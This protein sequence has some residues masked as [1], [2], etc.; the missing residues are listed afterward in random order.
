ML[1]NKIKIA[2]NKSSS[3]M[4]TAKLVLMTTAVL[5]SFLF[6]SVKSAYAVCSL[7]DGVEGEMVYNV[8]Y[9]VAQFCDGT[10]WIGMTSGATS[11][12]SEVG[13]DIYFNSG[14]VGIGVNDPATTL[15]LNGAMSYREMVAP[16][17]APV[18]QGRIYFD[19][20]SNTFKV[21]ENNGAY[22]DLVGGGAAAINDL[23]DGV[24][25][26]TSVF[27]GSGSGV[28]DNG[29]NY[30]TAV[31]IDSLNSM[32]S[33][34][35]NTAMGYQSLYNHTGS[36]NTATGS[37]ALYTNTGNN[38]TATGRNAMYSNSTGHSNAAFGMD[39]LSSNTDGFYN[40][41]FGLNSLST[42]TT[43]DYNTA[44]G[45]AALRSN[46]GGNYNTAV[47][48]IALNDNTSGN[49]NTATGRGS[50]SNNT[51]G[52]NNTAFGHE[53]L[54]TNIGGNYNAAFGAHALLNTVGNN[55]TAVGFNALLSNRAKIESTAIG[56]ASMQYADDTTSSVESY[57][58]AVGAYSLHGSTTASANTGTWN[59]ALGHSALRNN[60][61]G[62]NNTAIGYQ[63]LISNT[64]G[65]ANVASGRDSLMSNTTGTQNT[66]VGYGSLY[67]NV[68]GSY[69][70]SIGLNSLFSNVGSRYNIAI[71]NNAMQYAND[72]VNTS[73]STYNIAIGHNALRGST[74]PADNDGRWNTAVGYGSL[75]Y[76]TSGDDNMGYGFFTLN[77]NT[78]GRRNVAI[79]KMALYSNVGRTENTAVGHHSM[80]Y[81]NN[82]PTY[83]IESNNTALGAYSLH[84]SGDAAVNTGR[85][86]TALGHSAMRGNT[87]GNDNVAVGWD[88]LRTNTSG[89]S[90]TAV[91]NSSLAASA[92]G[93]YNTASGFESLLQN[94]SGSNN[95]AMGYNALLS[96]VARSGSTAIGSGSMQYADDT[97]G[98]F[99][100]NTAIGYMALQGS[101]TAANNT[102]MANTAIGDQV[103]RNNT[104]GSHNTSL[105]R[106]SLLSNTVGAGNL[107]SGEFALLSNVAKSESTALGYESMRYADSG[108]AADGSD[109]S[110]NTAVGAYSLQ[111]STTAADN[112]GTGNTAIGHTAL[113]ANTSGSNNT[114][115]GY[116]AGDNITTGSSNIIIG[117]GV[118][119]MTVDGDNQ[120]NI[121]NLIHG[122]ADTTDTNLSQLAFG[123]G[124][125]AFVSGIGVDMNTLTSSMRPP[126][127]TSAQQPTCDVT[128]A[129]AFRYN[130]DTKAM[131][132]CD[133]SG[134]WAALGAGS[135][136]YANGF[137]AG[138]KNDSPVSASITPGT[139]W[140]DFPGVSMDL[141]AAGV[142]EV[143]FN[144][145][146][147]VSGG[148]Y[149]HA[150]YAR[151]STIAGDLSGER[152]FAGSNTSSVVSSTVTMK[153][154]FTVT[155]PDTIRLQGRDPY[156]GGSLFVYNPSWVWHRLDVAGSTGSNL[157]RS[158]VSGWPDNIKCNVTNPDWGILKLHSSLAPSSD[159]LYY[160]DFFGTSAQVKFNA[161]G[162]HNSY[163]GIVASDCDSKTITE[164]YD[165]YQAF[166]LVGG[167]TTASSESMA[168]GW[169]DVI[170]CDVTGWG[171]VTLSLTIAP[172]SVDGLYYYRHSAST[173]YDI[174]YN[175][176][177]TY[178]S[179]TNIAANDCNKSIT[180]LY[181]DGQAFNT[182]SQSTTTSA[183]MVNGWP[184]AI[185]CKITSPAWNEVVF[186]PS[187][188]PYP[189]GT[190]Y[191][192]YNRGSTIYDLIFNAD[193][194]FN[195]VNN[196]TTTDCAKSITQLY[197]EKK[198]FNLV[199]GSGNGTTSSSNVSNQTKSMVAQWPDAIKCDVTSPAWGEATAF[200]SHAPYI[201]D[202]LY[203]YRF[204]A[205]SV[206]YD[207]IFNADGTFNSNRNIVTTD[208]E[209]T[210]AQL[211]EDYQ[212][213]DLVGGEGLEASESMIDG[214]P[215]SIKCDLTSPAHGVLV[216]S[217]L[218]AP[219]AIDGL[220]Y[221]NF[222]DAGT[223]Y[224]IKFNTDG[225]FNSYTNLTTT[226]CN[227]TITELYDAGQAFNTHTQT[228]HV[229]ASMVF[230]WPDAIKCDWSGVPTVF[231]LAHAPASGNHV[232]RLVGDLDYS[233]MFAADGSFDSYSNIGGGTTDCEK[234]IT[235][236]YASGQAFSL[237]GG[238]GDGS[239]SSSSV[240][241]Q[242]KSMVAQWP[243]VIK[244]DVT[245][246]AAGLLMF[247]LTQVNNDYYYSYNESGANYF[248]IYNAD[249]TFDN[250]GAS[251]TTTDCDNKTI[252]EL[253]DD[254]Q[255]FDMVGGE[256][257]SS[258]E[259]MVDGW[260]DTIKCNVTDPAFGEIVFN[261]N[262]MPWSSNGEYYY[263][264]T[265]SGTGYDIRFNADGSF[266]KYNSL[267]TTDCNKT[268]TELYDG[269]QAFNTHTQTS[270]SEA[271][272]V[273][274]WPDA[275][276]CDLSS[277]NWQDT[278]FY[279][280]FARSGGNYYYKTPYDDG[281]SNYYVIFT[282]D[283]A[284]AGY[285]GITASDCD[286]KSITQLYAS[287]QAF[288]LVGGGGDGSSSSSSVSN[289]SK[290]MVAQWPDSIK[291][292][293][294]NPAN[295]GPMVF[296]LKHA[297][298]S[299]NG[300]YYYKAIDIGTNYDIKYNA[301]GTFNSYS[302]IVASDCDGKT[303]AELYADY[304]AFDLVGG[305]STPVSE[306]MVTGWPDVIKCNVTSP[307]FGVTTFHLKFAPDPSDSLYKYSS[308]ESSNEYG[309]K[310]NTDGTFNSYTSLTTIDCNKTITEL[311]EDNQA[312]NTV[313]QTSNSE[314]S[315]V[316]GWPDAIKCDVTN[317]DWGENVFYL[318]AG[319]NGAGYYFYRFIYPDG[320]YDIKFN[321]DGSYAD[322]AG[323][324]TSGCLNK[325]ITQLYAEKKA[326]NLV[327]GSGGANV[328][329]D[330]ADAKADAASVYL[331]ER[332]GLN[333]DGTDN[334]NTGVGIDAL[335][336]NTSGYANTALGYG[337][338]ATTTV[339]YFNTAIGPNSLR[340]NVARSGSTAIGYW[341]MRYADDTTTVDEISFNTAVG[342]Y[343]L[344]GSS[345]PSA[346]TGI[347]NTAIG[348]SALMSNTSGENNTGLG[349][350]ALSLNTTGATNTGVGISALRNNTSGGGNVAVGSWSLNDNGTG[351]QNTA[352]GSLA[353]TSNVNNIGS[354]AVGYAA[355]SN[356]NDTTT[357]VTTFNTALGAYALRGS[358]V[359]ADNTGVRNTAIG[360]EALM[361]N[362]SG[363]YN[364]A[365]GR[366]TLTY[367][368]VG[369]K[370]TAIGAGNLYNNI[371]RSE[372]TAVGYNAMRWA[373]STVT[374]EPS[375]NTAVGTYALFGK[376]GVPSAN[377]G[378]DNTA[379]G[380]SAL[381]NNT[382]GSRNAA[383]GS[384]TLN[385]TTSGSNN[386]GFGRYALSTNVAK[387][388]STAVGYFSMR[389]A[390]NYATDDGTRSYNTAVGAHSLRGS[391]TASANTGTSNTALG[392]SALMNN[393]N[394]YMN[395]ALGHAA[396][397][398]NTTGHSNIAVGQSAMLVNISGSRNATLGV[399][400]LNDNTVGNNNVAIGRSALNTNVGKH[401]NTAVGYYSMVYA[402]DTAV[403]G[404]GG[405]TALGSYAL[406]GSL[407]A[408]NNTGT[409]NTALGHSS[410][411]ENSSGEH[412]N[413]LGYMSLRYN[414]TG[415]NNISF[416]SNTL[417]FNVGRNESTAI[418]HQSMRYA[419]DTTT[420]EVSYNTAVGAYSLQGAEN[421]QATNTGTM[422]TA[423]GHSALKLNTSGAWNTA[424]GYG[425]LTWTSTGHSNTASGYSSLMSNT[426]G[427][428]NVAIGRAALNDNK[429]RSESVA[430]GRW[431]MRYA[432]DTTTADEISYNTAVGTYSLMGSTT[433]S[434][435]TGTYNTAL[436]HKS[437][438]ANTSGGHNLAVGASA[439]HTNTTGVRNTAVGRTALFSNLGG[440]YNT[441]TG[442]AALY[443]N[444]SGE[445]NV[446]DGYGA[447]YYNTGEKNTAIGR[448]ALYNNV[449]RNEN[450]AV[451]YFAMVYADDTSTAGVSANT[452][453]GAHAL[454]GFATPSAN[455]G[456]QNTALGHN[457]MRANT[458]GDNNT[459]VG[460][461]SLYTNT[462]GLRNVAVGRTAL[463]YNL[464]GNYNTATGYGALYTNSS[465]ADNT[466]D[467]YAALHYNTGEKNTAIGRNALY[468]NVGRDENT[469]VGYSAMA[470]ADDTSTG[471]SSNTALGAYS[472]QGSLTPSANTGTSNT[473]IGHSV[474]MNNT[475]GIGNMGV[476]YNSL[477]DNT[478]GSYNS[479]SGRGAL[480]YNTT[481]YYNTA[482]GHAA[483]HTNAA[484]SESTAIG[485]YSMINADNTT[486]A[487]EISYNTAVGAYSLA[488][489]STASD[490]TGYSNTA[491]GH[492]VL[493]NNTSGRQNTAI[494]HSAMLDNTSGRGNVGIGYEA[495]EDNTSGSYNVGVGYYSMQK[496]ISGDDNAAF[497]R[498]AMY[499]NT[500]GDGNVA[501]GRSA[502]M[503]NIGSYNTAVG[504]HADLYS[505]TGNYN[506]AIGS[507]SGPASGSTNLLNTTAIGYE[508]YVTA[509]NTIQIGNS[510]VSAVYM[511]SG[512]TVTS[513]RRTKKD[514]KDSDLGLE[515][516][517]KLRPISYR[518]KRGNDRLDYGFVAQEV[519]EALDGRVTNMVK[520]KNDEM[521][522]YSL[523]YNHII[524]P[525]VKAVQELYAM[526]NPL[527]D[528]VEK[529][530]QENALIM[531]ELKKLR[532]E[533]D[534]LKGEK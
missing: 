244:C 12:W 231:F 112:T 4:R 265:I 76:N 79:G 232:Y 460:S 495:L 531:D 84:G 292:N 238:R 174:K 44:L 356:A 496:N 323:V 87:S 317:P 398:A 305:N 358:G 85:R 500:T 224:N 463:F 474:L 313:S 180:E 242:S 96:N 498:Y 91:G 49:E 299:D 314:A 251:L 468:N 487:D 194:S 241:N 64:S 405:N 371:G 485:Y 77:N 519:E 514:I 262:Y 32:V 424:L 234:S 518:F 493:R 209:E 434:A 340:T 168:V 432:D 106:A 435:N 120:L 473:A 35:N 376:E 201:G 253:Y 443:T 470:Y 45:T 420:D 466:A 288:S 295:L 384:N 385:E 167:D 396:L 302:T 404:I 293:V 261:A 33:G 127:G 368:T 448:S 250:N 243:D 146:A 74:T 134:S 504:R 115:L 416:G 331:G 166:D 80:Y 28:A 187:L 342:A 246:P 285:N 390:D 341:S 415:D 286:S 60:A 444:S 129:G 333:D 118:D 290:S 446:A 272:M 526:I 236:L 442:Y 247:R 202:G 21:S 70:I 483:L 15:D 86:N 188:F 6:T 195:G 219:Y 158:M 482:N 480:A 344:Q 203:Y 527:S 164:L 206:L 373:D 266:N 523:T 258:S 147:Y 508:A 425:S 365:L 336:L 48:S 389:Y 46:V 144:A 316:H 94:V 278:I 370:N 78:V 126:V 372:S 159:G 58:T 113:I 380:H 477:N 501:V 490:N 198:A 469:A 98:G 145:R 5:S 528:K 400:A 328:I 171:P 310:F 25:D 499:A 355:M 395:T 277:P 169:P 52:N 392:H 170:K 116:L 458:S 351:G 402:N 184:D 99:S 366:G 204:I 111:G 109:I 227:K 19:S 24:S 61:S 150:S 228:S 267:V 311:Y 181:T 335:N 40:V 101:T 148:T 163:T 509:S 343:S 210:I 503:N 92:T 31:G 16:A 161:D 230:G 138:Y 521:K 491:I 510:S 353:L 222:S 212:A 131:E 377:T 121:G 300:W 124:V 34:Q 449:G 511:R 264:K 18:N 279:L 407:T 235:Q 399:E 245:S 492:S 57:N 81:A 345:T 532:A 237:V 363:G 476:G 419:D 119:A 23:T 20:T 437:L 360:H 433:P 379:V 348:H 135:G 205:P 357:G 275:I 364:T 39:A 359:A 255:A 197:A 475:S 386:S 441:A 339:G 190:Y 249:G 7:P 494:G 461:G 13:F 436:G 215:D 172:Y 330:L 505:N 408:A 281:N 283:G 26:T 162:T 453:L 522:T 239:S 430:V 479:A 185:K 105:G 525:V 454:R 320:V 412:N 303:I 325:S 73:Q 93:Y 352:V 89:A 381:L 312:F 143:T 149:K 378:I 259:S 457:S 524:S 467:G 464:D 176:D 394:G 450:T 403:A 155:G 309:L 36:N 130:S 502:G 10:N 51:T 484:R 193:G 220:Y 324:V 268:I 298:R 53:S 362:T 165:D 350:L 456:I 530:E 418:G 374:E 428:S 308:V 88:A 67:N 431:S 391:L 177:G 223:D 465:G 455:T 37:Q 414:T 422:N 271:S 83:G 137:L 8:D 270:N 123:N 29:T 240:S 287:G 307:A 69:N 214:W 132:Y 173:I 186:V 337:T 516:I 114:A 321:S 17:I 459:A 229:E 269:G 104:S 156:A 133:G 282:S 56:Y 361:S 213:F 291:C 27:L 423:I 218:R 117:S 481:G 189:S 306:T 315:M 95:T 274:G 367:N 462:T 140:T 217:L 296:T 63:A 226:D 128:T 216:L 346:N 107:A 411:A 471:I 332:S 82:S 489:S 97:S 54:Y 178:N 200:L 447:L 50:L 65:A 276:K 334:Y 179:A 445:D 318:I 520:Q 62:T 151:L 14:A 326:F 142:Y 38:N 207:V 2:G 263:G 517:N 388:E 252:T 273:N 55:N 440:N 103:M 90:N 472:L 196:I 280:T 375:Y 154:T 304:Q 294:T 417:T 256:G 319:P 42:N 515:F 22:V 301:D 533:M 327:G 429:A 100:Y 409:Y 153:W 11:T 139:T 513:D 257:I 439:L 488:G 199:G 393:T 225:T 297:P 72:T 506:T 406:R 3:V 534:A 1:E 512:V 211:Y 369:E 136:T 254:G 347:R 354:T 47:G 413:S 401:E 208:C 410:L 397:S 284:S 157:S 497:G 122:L 233:V 507:N 438:Q 289:Q 192:T 152:A 182:V 110:Y 383:F 349:N 108:G 248:M 191:Y 338:L 451:G 102:G 478:T 183:S 529:L 75:Q 426:T 66:A 260:P 71:G 382:S 329:N 41:A 68:G 43:G 387:H 221:Y 125:T 427:Y 486:T 160:Y 452:A 175:P 59:T 322:K 421:G 141:P 9:K 30:N